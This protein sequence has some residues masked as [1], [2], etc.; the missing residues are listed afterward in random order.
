MFRHIVRIVLTLA[1][2]VSTALVQSGPP[3]A[4]ACHSPRRARSSAAKPANRCK[5]FPQILL[6]TVPPLYYNVRMIT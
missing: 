5:T 1:L 6:T 2:I 3:T 4:A